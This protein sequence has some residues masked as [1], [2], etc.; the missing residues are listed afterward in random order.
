MKTLLCTL[1]LFVCS[2]AATVLHAATVPSSSHV[3]IVMEENHSY[4]SVI[5]NKA[6]P[7][8]NSLA[9]KYGVAT[10]YYA[11]THPSIGNYFMITA[12]QVITN[13]DS[14]C[15]TLTQ[16][17]IVRHLLTAGKTWK[18]YAEN[19]PYAGYTG[20]AKYPY[21]KKHN[22]LAFYSDVA[23]SSEKYNLVPFTK[24]ASDLANRNLPQYSFIVPNLLHDGHDGSL[25]AA[26]AWL[27]ANIAP[28]IASSTFQKDG[29]LVIVFDESVDSDK[30]HGG[31]HVACV[32]VGP[33]VKRGYRSKA[34]YQHQNTL[35]T[36]MQALGIR[37]FPGA[38]ASAAGMTDLF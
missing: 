1:T 37:S 6:M 17:N 9:S 27:K 23:N 21:A 16:D 18:S 8:L 19:L 32:V 10:Q 13:K 33:H 30:Q 24:F 22:P 14:F 25:P 20:C 4:A 12:G 3:F 34:L 35:K 28:L 11:N 15:G 5:G 38:S 31:G 7:Y 29:I 2:L 26:D 36:L